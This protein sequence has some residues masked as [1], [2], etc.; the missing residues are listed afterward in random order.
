MVARTL[1]RLL[2]PASILPVLFAGPALVRAPQ[3]L[4]RQAWADV[5]HIENGASR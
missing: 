1:A 2:L 4:A 3:T 5:Q